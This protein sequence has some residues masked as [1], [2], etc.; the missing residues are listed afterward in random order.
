MT[1]SAM[2]RLVGAAR[3]LLGRSSV[4]LGGVLSH[5]EFSRVS[6]LGRRWSSFATPR[7][8]STAASTSV[9]VSETPKEAPKETE[10]ERKRRVARANEQEAYW[11]FGIALFFIG[12]IVAY[13]YR[14]TANS[15]KRKK[16]EQI[17]AGELAMAPDEIDQLWSSNGLKPAQFE[18]LRMRLLKDFPSGKASPA[19]FFAQVKRLL[20][21]ESS[22][23]KCDHLLERLALRLEEQGDELDLR[24]LLTATTMLMD[25]EPF[26]RCDTVFRLFTRASKADL[27]KTKMSEAQVEDAVDALLRTGQLPVR[28]M[29]REHHSYP[30]ND[31]SRANALSLMTRASEEIL[32]TRKKEK[33]TNPPQGH[34]EP[35]VAKLQADLKVEEDPLTE[36]YDAK[37]RAAL[38]EM[39]EPVWSNKD[40]MDLMLTYKICAWGE[41]NK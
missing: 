7:S 26:E 6:V 5:A 33:K 14:G 18:L 11:F 25:V 8:L 9:N 13:F 28:C 2:A 12:S 10:E 41:C 17:L 36:N 23:V 38:P 34:E 3:P 1:M 22:A 16:L 20:D 21:S 29:V 35:M 37:A 27:D 4:S 24:V 19:A 15:K 32:K 30:T 39:Q 31:Y 40:F